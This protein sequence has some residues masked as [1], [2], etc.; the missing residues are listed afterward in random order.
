MIRIFLLMSE[1]YKFDIEELLGDLR[2]IGH[3]TKPLLGEDYGFG[4]DMKGENNGTTPLYL[5]KFGSEVL[6]ENLLK[7]FGAA[8]ICSKDLPT[9]VKGFPGW[10]NFE[11]IKANY[12]THPI[13]G[14]IICSPDEEIFLRLSSS[15]RMFPVRSKFGPKLFL[16]KKR[17][18]PLYAEIVSYIEKIA[19]L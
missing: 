13:F 3:R 11:G 7:D 16:G 18:S 12:W 4:K 17:V 8:K 5:S 1:E 10:K 15:Y 6:K 19:K 14:E 9:K 2:T